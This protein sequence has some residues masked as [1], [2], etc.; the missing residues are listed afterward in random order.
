MMLKKMVRSMLL[1][2]LLIIL[3]GAFRSPFGVAY[4]IERQ[5][6][7]IASD[8]DFVSNQFPGTGT[9]EDPYIIENYKITSIGS[10]TN[11]IEVRGTSKYFII[12]NC[13]ITASYIGILVE[14]VSPGTASVI[15]NTI[16]AST[17]D[18]GDIVLGADGVL[19]SNNTCTNFIDGI[20]TNYASDCIIRDNNFS[21]N[22]Y[23]GISLRYSDNNI[24]THNTITNNGAYVVLIIRESA[25]N[26]I[27]NNTI[28]DN[29]KIE[30]YDWDSIY[31]FVVEQQALDGGATTYGTTPKIRG[32]TCGR[33][34][35]EQGSTLSTALRTQ[36]I[37]IRRRV[38]QP[39]L[40]RSIRRRA[41]THRRGYR[42]SWPSQ[43]C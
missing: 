32:A 11:A 25:S 8:N 27:F 13:Q 9:K 40:A 10:M 35:L 29:A 17:S 15:N 5:P 30:S 26:K 24:V 39:P 31:N 34:I 43:L 23:H 16:T 42:G 20:H 2:S 6:I 36:S 7:L 37:N 19:V 33:T 21:K 38:N 4:K 14:A 3:I 22:H 12:R 41:E 28:I 18:G 1:T